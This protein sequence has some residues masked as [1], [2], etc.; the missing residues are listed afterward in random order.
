V[1]H[2]DRIKLVLAVL[3]LASFFLSVR[4]GIVA[5]RWTGI[6]LVALAYGLRFA[7]RP[8]PPPDDQLPSVMR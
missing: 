2:L 4:T 5:L 8:P 3:G 6:G 1:R 7:R